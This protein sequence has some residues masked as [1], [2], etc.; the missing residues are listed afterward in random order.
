MTVSGI[1]CA[2]YEIKKFNSKLKSSDFVFTVEIF[3]S[4]CL[5]DLLILLKR[6]DLTISS[7][8]VE[9]YFEFDSF[10]CK[11]FSM[12]FSSTVWISENK[13]NEQ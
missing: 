2:L 12:F 9:Y 3:A 1:H 6:I 13:L 11:N 4:K 8:F 10:L 7:S 5:Y